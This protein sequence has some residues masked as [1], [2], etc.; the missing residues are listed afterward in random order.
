LANLSSWSVRWISRLGTRWLPFADA[1]SEELPLPRLLRLSLFQ[2]SV[3]MALTLLAGTI[4][5]VMIV[6]LW[7]SAGIVAAMLALPMLLAPFRALVGFRSDVHRSV[8]GW[9][10]VPYIWFGTLL[11]FGGFAIMPFGLL[12][13]GARSPDPGWLA[14]GGA[15]LAFLLVGAGAHTVQT[16]GLALATDLAK[17]EQRPR[18]V[19][20]L[21]L[22]L[23][24]GMVVAGLVYAR[25]LRDYTPE[26]LIQVVQ[27]AA[28]VT[29]ALNLVA[30]WKQ[31]PRR[32]GEAGTEAP[33][34][35]DFRVAWARFVGG[36]RASRLLVAV[37]LGA[38]GFGMQDILL[39]PYGGEVVNLGVG[40]TSVLTALTASGAIG[41]FA[42]SA[43]VLE[44]GFDPC[45]LA[46]LGT[47]VGVFAFAA[48]IFA[49]PFQS[50]TL[51]RIGSTA[52]GFGGGLFL[53]GT[54]TEAMDLETSE[55]SG[56]AMGAWGAVQATAAGLAIASGG[57][58]R[59]VLIEWGSRGALGP[60][61]TG[62]EAGYVL[63]YH[64]EILALFL[65]MAVLGP[66]VR[67]RRRGSSAAP[68]GLVKMPG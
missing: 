51:L 61:L 48:V 25:L 11:Q 43:R 62:P 40:A 3:G 60:G 39:E 56:L 21:Y 64:L 18:V 57:V 38:V 53:V 26:R 47:L 5:R 34:I 6:E 50:A 20:L 31:E 10:R 35:D 23:L 30:I 29:V 36:G 4:N 32:A 49:S 13:L 19:A 42:L 54:L 65:A 58:L 17:P 55:H 67:P 16:A 52:I 24:V 33:G 22:M 41:A 66:L 14:T 63:V 15:A 9:R 1:G 46:A 27:G 68:F 37:G 7:V 8:L 44:R 28:L 12:L 59:D 2:V 45:R